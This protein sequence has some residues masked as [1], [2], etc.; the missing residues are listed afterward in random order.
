MPTV[1]SLR[2]D[3]SILREAI[4]YI[5]SKW[6]NPQNRQVYVDCLTHTSNA[7]NPLPQW[8]LLM[9]EDRI[10]GCAGLITNDFI[11]RMDLYPWVC[12]MYIEQ[13]RRG[14]NF[15]EL[16]IKKAVEDA[17]NAGFNEVYLCTDHV[18]YYEHFGFGFV[19]IGYHPWGESSRIYSLKIKD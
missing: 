18:G 14:N 10:I 5:A 1:I 19:G 16:L 15:G 9:E 8:Y 7:K 13:D 2:Q 6:A 12:A 4:Q 11:S 3:A 17:K